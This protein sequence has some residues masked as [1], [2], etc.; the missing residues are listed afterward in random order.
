[1][2]IDN[3]DQLSIFDFLDSDD[4]PRE[5]FS[6]ENNENDLAWFQKKDRNS[7]PTD[8]LI[9]FDSFMNYLNEHPIQLTKKMGYISRK[10]LPT[11]N[12]LLSIKTVDVTDYSQ[13]EYYPYI[14]FFYSLALTGKL[15][16]KVTDSTYPHLEITGRWND[17]KQLT[18]TEKYFFLLETF[19]VDLNWADILNQNTNPIILVIEDI[20]TK[21]LDTKQL[22]LKKSLLARLTYNWNYFFLYLE[23]FGLWVCETDIENIESA[24][25]KTEYYV[26]SILLTPFAEKIVPILLNDRHPQVWNIPYRRENGE[27]NP[28]PGSKLPEGIEN[29]FDDKVIFNE[30]QSSHDFHKAFT[31]LFTPKLLQK[32]LPRNE[33]KFTPGT[34]TFK[35]IYTNYS[36]CKVMLGAN[37]TMADLHKIIIKAFEFDDDHLYSFF[38]DGKKWSRNSIVAP[39][40]I[41]GNPIA[42][43]VKIGAAGLDVRKK[44]IY[45][46]DYGDEWT[47]NVTVEQI[48]EEIAEPMTP[49]LIERIGSGPEQYFFI[50]E[51]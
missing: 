27:V 4:E 35:I 25:R 12:E 46:Y 18:D 5:P 38:M 40:D 8:F 47:F 11:I 41:S 21:L 9:D 50:E 16:E 3:Q 33:R 10:H 49:S 15:V 2:Y 23:W 29:L 20:F 32:T 28:I 42:T 34:Y 6:N 48:E 14:H 17:Y 13:Q 19:W 45:L 1:M 24:N 36:W 31:K 37:H 39:L 44:F 22:Q 7:I 51:E 26:N 30:D 43:D